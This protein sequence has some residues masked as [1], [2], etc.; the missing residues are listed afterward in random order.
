MSEQQV[1][2][3]NDKFCITCGR[4]INILAE[5]CPHCGVRQIQS[6]DNTSS[7]AI[8][9]A[10]NGCLGFF[11]CMGIGHM[12]AGSVAA[13]IILLL[14]GWGIT[15]FGMVIGAATFGIGTLLFIVIYLIVYIWSIINVKEV[16]DRKSRR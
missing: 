14:G 4:V 9:M 3:P 5:I 1:R 13:G 6:P 16:I 15:V 11:G 12:V 2:G 7:V 8:P 10:L